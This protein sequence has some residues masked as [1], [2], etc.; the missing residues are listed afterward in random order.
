MNH[1]ELCPFFSFFLGGFALLP[2]GAVVRKSDLSA[3]NGVLHVIEDVM[4]L[5]YAP[6]PE[7]PR[8]TF[9]KDLWENVL[10]L[11]GKGEVPPTTPPPP[12]EE[13]SITNIISTLT[14]LSN[15]KEMLDA[16]NVTGTIPEL[17]KGLLVDDSK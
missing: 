10:D 11:F 12:V 3:T 4:P 2:N 13:P 5:D 7:S 16:L 9:W 17:Q 8:R 6:Q 1:L 15:A 14:K